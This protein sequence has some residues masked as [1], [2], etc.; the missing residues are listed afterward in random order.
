MTCVVPAYIRGKGIEV[1]DEMK[2]F[3]HE[4]SICHVKVEHTIGLLK[5]HFLCLKYLNIFMLDK[6]SMKV[7]IDSG[8]VCCVIVHNLLLPDEE[9]NYNE[10]AIGELDLGENSPL[11]LPA[12]Q[13]NIRRGI[14]CCK[15]YLMYTLFYI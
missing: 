6:K 3:F 8:I 14:S 11:M 4:L 7:L 1:L 5:N 12:L 15:H 13:S 9:H 2:M 10:V